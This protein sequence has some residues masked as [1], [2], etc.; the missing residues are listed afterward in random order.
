VVALLALLVLSV[1]LWPPTSAAQAIDLPTP[2]ATTTLAPSPTVSPAVDATATLPPMTPIPT[3][4]LQLT[5]IV[6]TTAQ[7]AVAERDAW[8]LASPT[9]PVFLSLGGIVLLVGLILFVIEQ[10]RA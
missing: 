3:V 4:V 2:T 8:S 9:S 5:E 7:V 10:F 1:A 6:S